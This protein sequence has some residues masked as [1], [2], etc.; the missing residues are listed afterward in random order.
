MTRAELNRMIIEAL[1]DQGLRK[2]DLAR[3]L[4][5]SKQAVSQSLTTTASRYDNIRIQSMLKLGI[6]CLVSELPNGLE[7]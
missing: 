6:D 2:I 5:I 4:Q 3:R 1:E 7:K